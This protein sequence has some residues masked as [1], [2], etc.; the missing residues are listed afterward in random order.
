[1]T[2]EKIMYRIVSIRFEIENYRKARDFRK[3]AELT[4]EMARLEGILRFKNSVQV[5]A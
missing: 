5:G 2:N 4:I 3:V 1:M